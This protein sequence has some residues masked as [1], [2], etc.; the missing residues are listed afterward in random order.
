MGQGNPGRGG[1]REIAAKISG[2][3]SVAWAVV[4]GMIVVGLAALVLF[5]V[6][7]NAIRQ[8]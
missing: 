6:L 7:T 5:A 3:K 8:S 1:D 2:A 4:R